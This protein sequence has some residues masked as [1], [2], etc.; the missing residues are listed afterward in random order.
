MDPAQAKEQLLRAKQ[1]RL[2]EFI[3]EHPG[4]LDE[5]FRFTDPE[6]REAAMASV[7]Q[8]DLGAVSL[9]CDRIAYL[10]RTRIVH[11]SHEVPRCGGKIIYTEKDANRK[12]NRIWDA[13]RGRMRV[14]HCPHCNGHHLTHS[15]PRDCDQR[16]A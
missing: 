13:G 8:L 11:H 6:V 7:E 4:Q 2:K 3:H 1:D 9:L 10:G 14:Y 5:L 16:M 15:A 12:A